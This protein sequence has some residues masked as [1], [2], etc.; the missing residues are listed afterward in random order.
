MGAAP[1]R[2]LRLSL[3]AWGLGEVAMGRRYAGSTWLL[4]EALGLALIGLLSWLLLDTT[5]YLVPFLLGM[6]FI[7][8][9]GVQAL[10]GYRR[11]QRLAGQAT[12][13]VGRRSPAAAAAWLTLPLL[14]WGT[15]FWLVAADQ[16]SPA[17]VVDRFL[18]GWADVAAGHDVAWEETD[19]A[20][21]VLLSSAAA[22]ATARLRQLCANGTLPSDCDE[23]P[24]SVL[25]DVRFR[26]DGPRDGV[27]VAVAEVVRFERRPTTFLGIFGASELVP[28]ALEEI[29]RLDLAA[30]PA[31]LG[32]QR[33]T[34]VAASVP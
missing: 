32:S 10:L 9:W 26:I 2:V 20:D 27:A 29:L 22:D 13:P 30:R 1:G 21:P 19:G 28:V 18:S 25:R 34:V 31:A 12:P 15:G 11:A 3:V 6:A 24:G 7:G 17:A 23:D 33:W 4:A 8:V 14:A 16:A 5:W